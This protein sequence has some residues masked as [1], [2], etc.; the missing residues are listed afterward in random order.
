MSKMR[1]VV[2]RAPR[3]AF[4][5]SATCILVLPPNLFATPLSAATA[6]PRNFRDVVAGNPSLID[7]FHGGDV[8]ASVKK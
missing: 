1:A 4:L 7:V 2:S 5:N 8:W 6:A 3:S